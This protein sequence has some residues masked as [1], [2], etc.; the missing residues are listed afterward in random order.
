MPDEFGF[1]FFPSETGSRLV[2]EF[3]SDV[4]SSQQAKQIIKK[5]TPSREENKMAVDRERNADGDYL[6]FW[7]AK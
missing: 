7:D 3:N 1:F 4:F 6:S 5:C 2:N